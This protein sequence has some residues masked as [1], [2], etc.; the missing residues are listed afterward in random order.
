MKA[1]SVAE[2]FVGV[3]ERIDAAARISEILK[4]KGISRKDFAEMVGAPSDRVYKVLGAFTTGNAEELAKWERYLERKD[5]GIEMFPKETGSEIYRVIMKESKGP[6]GTVF[7][8]K[9]AFRWQ[10][11]VN[12]RIKDSGPCSSYEEGRAEIINRAFA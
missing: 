5:D 3:R 4:E 8:G 7:P 9:G 6:L 10:Y 12:G 1:G 2:G 11:R